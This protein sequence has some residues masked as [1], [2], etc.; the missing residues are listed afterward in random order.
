MDLRF[1][2][3]S[4]DTVH[5]P[6][7][8]RLVKVVLWLLIVVNLIYLYYRVFVR[9][10]TSERVSGI[11]LSVLTLLI[12]LI[13]FETGFMFFAQTHGVA[14]T[15]ASALW[16]DKYYK[17]VNSLGYRDREPNL[18]TAKKVVL[19]VGDSFTAGYGNDDV[20]DRFSDMVAS[21]LDTTK[22]T[23]ITWAY[24]GSTPG[25]KPPDSDST[26]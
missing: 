3:I 9:R 24:R 4:S 17:P 21:G 8:V 2:N 26:R 5:D 14:T 16:V 25:R 10:K 18:K 6:L 23:S 11:G 7:P 20:K 1:Q 12:T 15:R 22:S 13:F 19:F